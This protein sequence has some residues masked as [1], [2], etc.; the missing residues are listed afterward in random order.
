LNSEAWNVILKDNEIETSPSF[1][2]PAKCLV[3]RKID[4]VGHEE[5][6]DE[7]VES[8]TSQY[9]LMISDGAVEITGQI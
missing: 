8:Q 1:L 7:L 6:Q 2:L 5:I 3:K 9:S 4:C